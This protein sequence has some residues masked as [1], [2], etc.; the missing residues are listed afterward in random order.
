MILLRGG[1]AV[2]LRAHDLQTCNP[3]TAVAFNLVQHVSLHEVQQWHFPR[4]RRITTQFASGRRRAVRCPR[5]S[6]AQPKAGRQESCASPSQKREITRTKTCRI[7]HGTSSLRSSIRMASNLSTRK[8][9]PAE[10][11]AIS[12]S[13]STLRTN[14]RPVEVKAQRAGHPRHRP[15][16]PLRRVPPGVPPPEVSRPAQELGKQQYGWQ[17][18]RESLRQHIVSELLG[19]NERNGFA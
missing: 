5:K 3:H 7:F 9:Q 8:K 15:A 2:L 16:A 17:K 12:I 13:S 14:T 6:P 10:P 18:V 4:R 11:R 1:D 19:P